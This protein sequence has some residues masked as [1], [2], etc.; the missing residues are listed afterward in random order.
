MKLT[1]ATVP[2]VGKV[3]VTN[4][5]QMFSL[6]LGAVLLGAVWKIASAWS[7]KVTSMNFAKY[8]QP[9]AAQVQ[10]KTVQP[11]ANEGRVV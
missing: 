7:A 1:N 8:L 10:Q 11:V 3:N 4:V 5:G 2:G 6:F 9:G